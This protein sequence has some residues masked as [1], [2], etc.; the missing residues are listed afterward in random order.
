MSQ[1]KNEP[2]V[3]VAQ[4]Q[5]TGKSDPWWMFQRPHYVGMERLPPLAKPEKKENHSSQK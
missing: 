4:E 2:K 1:E 5:V 3:V